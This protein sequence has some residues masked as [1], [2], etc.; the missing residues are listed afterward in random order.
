M[1]I[2][3]PSDWARPRGYSNGIL[4][5]GTLLFVAGQ[6]GWTAQAELA[7]ADLVG[8]IEQALKN[9]VTILHEGGTRP[10]HIVRLTWYV[11]DKREYIAASKAIGDVYRKNIGAHYPAMTLVEVADLLVDGAKVEIEATAVIPREESGD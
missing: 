8:Q 9:I 1:T 10:E 3:Q 2:L 7:A 11:T 6:I 5:D 4:S